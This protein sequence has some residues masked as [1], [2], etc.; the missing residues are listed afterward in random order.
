MKDNVPRGAVMHQHGRSMRTSKTNHMAGGKCESKSTHVA[1]KGMRDGHQKAVS[2]LTTKHLTT[3]S[4]MQ[5]RSKAKPAV[6]LATR[7][8]AVSFVDGDRIVCKI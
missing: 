8:K 5:T 2:A 1:H 3:T 4:L 6:G 7:A